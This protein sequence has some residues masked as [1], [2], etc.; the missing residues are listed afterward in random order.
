MTFWWM[1]R[2]EEHLPSD[3]TWLSER[4]TAY[5]D[6]KQFT[7]R[8]E[9]YLYA[10]WTA[11]QALRTVLD[12]P[13]TPGSLR[14]IEVRHRPTGAPV[15]CVDGEPAGL[16]ISLTDRAGWAVCV[17]SDQ[18]GRIGCDLEL[19]EPRTDGFVRDYLTAAEQRYVN[20]APDADTRYLAAN[21]IWSATESALKV[22]ETG[23]RR[24]T[25][26]VEITVAPALAGWGE[27]SARTEEGE[28]FPGWWR[29]LGSFILTVAAETDLP[30]P[31]GLDETPPLDAA[32]PAH[33]WV[34]R[35]I[36]G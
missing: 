16:Q 30:L 20:A 5:V 22:L 36:S 9:E 31:A 10:R 2:G 13:A 24:D 26:S 6:S 4:E 12:L 18:P 14:R 15:A 7:K 3:L 29:R 1:S 33:S 21:L 23:L 27:L 34:H 8:R 32:Q 11:K 28:V 35:P 25:R 19:V 17:L